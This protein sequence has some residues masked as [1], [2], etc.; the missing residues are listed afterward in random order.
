LSQANSERFLRG[1]QM[2]ES[3]LWNTTEVGLL[4]NQG[5][6]GSCWAV[7]AANMVQLN[8]FIQTKQ[9]R[10]F[11][12]QELV[13]C[14]PN[15]KQCGGTGGCSGATVE[16]AVLYMSRQ[17]LATSEETPYSGV[18][19]NCKTSLLQ[20]DEDDF[21]D[22]S[23]EE[24]AKPGIK[25]VK[26]ARAK[27]IQFVNWERLPVNELQPLKAALLE[28]S[29]A[30]SVDGSP[31]SLYSSGVFDS[32]SK[33]A[34]INHAVLALGY[35]QEEGTNTKFWLIQ[36]SWGK[37]WGENGRI[38]LLRTDDDDNVCGM[39]TRPQD[40]TACKGGPAQVKVCGMCGILYDNVIARFGDGR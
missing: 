3:K 1:S 25:I 19:S 17:G 11:S 2:P 6:C 34:T 16:L 23:M 14:T 39:D 10:S 30:V 29:V 13:D 35:G 4:E 5:G 15:P 36:N 21:E 40:G 33:G 28:A 24:L 31:W 12:A 9:R 37:G 26:S 20:E 32:C 7:A 27:S 38:K 8:Y 22:M 18:D